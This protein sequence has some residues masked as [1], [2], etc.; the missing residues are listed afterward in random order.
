MTKPI[1]YFTNYHPGNGGLLG[2]MEESWGSTFEVL[3]PYQ[4]A[5]LIAAVSTEI[6]SHYSMEDNNN[7]S[8][9]EEVCERLG[10]LSLG[11]QLGLLEALINQAKHRS[12]Q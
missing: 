9:V 5:Y 4:R 3:T 7:D 10:E 8:E 1:A 12:Q 6:F 2:D 11:D